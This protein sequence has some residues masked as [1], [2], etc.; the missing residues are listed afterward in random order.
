MSTPKTSKTKT[1]AEAFDP[2]STDIV[3]AGDGSTAQGDEGQYTPAVY[4]ENFDDGLK[5]ARMV[6]PGLTLVHGV[7]DYKDVFTVGTLVVGNLERGAEVVKGN[8]E[9]FKDEAKRRNEGRVVIAVVGVARPVY[10]P[11]V[12]PDHPDFKKEVADLKAVAAAGGT[13]DRKTSF[14]TGAQ[15]WAAKSE[16]TLLV[17]KPDWVDAEFDD[18]FP[19]ELAGGRW[20]L[21][22]YYAKKSAFNNFVEPLRSHKLVHPKL[23]DTKNAAGEVVKGRLYGAQFLLGVKV[24][25]TPK[26]SF[27]APDIVP[28]NEPIAQEVY[29]F[30]EAVDPSRAPRHA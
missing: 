9:K 27:F 4:D 1:E 6:L 19:H 22:K 14:A 23:K 11:D 10:Q 25:Q 15:L 30:C 16:C 5:A 28:S 7:G 12:K 8:L 24:I 29:D 26:N 17:R 3:S 2:M 18:L 20:A 13:T 21:V